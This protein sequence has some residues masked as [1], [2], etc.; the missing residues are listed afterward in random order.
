MVGKARPAAP[1]PVLVAELAAI[2]AVDQAGVVVAWDEAA[3]T[4][5]GYH[6]SEAIGASLADLIIPVRLHAGLRRLGVATLLDTRIDAPVVDRAGREFHVEVQVTHDDGRFVGHIRELP[7]PAPLNIEWYLAAKGFERRERVET[8]RMTTLIE[9]LNVGILLQDEQQRVVLTNSAFVEFF[10]VG[11][12]PDKLR[13]TA[14]RGGSFTHAFADREAAERR[15]AETV[16]GGRPRMGEEVR[17]A[18]GLVLERDYVPVTLDGATLGHLWVFRDVTAQAEI[19]RGLEE[20]NRMLTEVSDLKTEFVRVASHELRTPLTSIATFSSMLEQA[21]GL[22]PEER[23]LAVAAIRRN[24]ERMQVLVADLL[25]LAQ[26]E[27]G[28]VSLC[29]S[30]V[31]LVALAK[32][33]C[34]AAASVGEAGSAGKPGWAVAMREDITSGPA[35]EGDAVLLRQLFATAVGVVAAAADPGAPVT[36]TAE[37]DETGWTFEVTTETAEPATAERLLST[38]LPHPAVDGE[39]RTGALALMLA[40]EIAARHAGKLTSSVA[41]PGMTVLVKLPISGNRGWT[42]QV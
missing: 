14:P 30:Q 39:Y 42:T 29:P 5:F 16:R 7:V 31:D 40:R 21:A 20:R 24:A 26:L 13:G 22:A 11:L 32:E 9:A 33:A 25:L 17:L 12:T 28:E 1:E 34:T 15:I 4:L 27:S 35:V 41:A 23:E 36:A 18:D 38:R 6:P 2:V 37:A 8:A 19:R 3:A 10:A